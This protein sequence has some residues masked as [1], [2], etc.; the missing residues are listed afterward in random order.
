MARRN[1]L[2][3]LLLASLTLLL[4]ACMADIDQT[5]TFLADE[6]WEVNL[7]IAFPAEVAPLAAG[8][9]DSEL[10]TLEQSIESQG[11]ALDWERRDDENGN[12][13]YTVDASGQGY[14][15]LRDV[16][17]DVQVATETR[18]G[19][20]V[21]AFT[22]LPGSD[23]ELASSYTMTL[24]GGEIISSNGIETGRGQVQWQNPAGT[25]E[26]VLTEQSALGANWLL[27][28]LIGLV[29]LALVGAAVFLLS[30]RRSAGRA[31]APAWSALPPEAPPTYLTPEPPR[32]PTPAAPA[33]PA[34]Q[35]CTQCGASLR[36]GA[37]FCAACGNPVAPKPY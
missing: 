27:P 18:N 8:S 37:K 11:G 28:A 21:I 5:I 33:P 20:R 31:A 32:P 30:R 34:G 3:L 6:R 13:T 36:P 14:D 25:M 26:A 12:L 4:A 22:Y 16:V 23:L 10:T 24:V 19:E 2:L 15:M 1:S 7:L 9:V 17:G 35:F 29:V